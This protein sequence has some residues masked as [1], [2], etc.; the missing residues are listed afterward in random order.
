[1]KDDRQQVSFLC[2]LLAVGLNSNQRRDYAQNH[3]T[4]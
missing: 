2:L 4:S 1:V 3:W